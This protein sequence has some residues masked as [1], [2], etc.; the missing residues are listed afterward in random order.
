[1]AP[2]RVR[3]IE[4]SHERGSTRA[5]ATLLALLLCSLGWLAFTAS[6][7]S[8]HP[9]YL[10]STP[11]ANAVVSTAPSSITISYT[12]GLDYTYCHVSLVSPAGKTLTT[13]RVPAPGASELKV[14]P[15]PL[16]KGT[17]AVE[18]TAIGD[19]GHVVQGTFGFSVGAPS[20][21]P[22]VTAGQ[23]ASVG[24]AGSQGF[25]QVPLRVLLPVALMPFVGILLLVRF[26]PGSGR[27]EIRAKVG[28]RLAR[29]RLAAWAA[30]LAILLGLALQSVLF[31][32]LSDLVQSLTGRILLVFLG[33]Y[34]LAGVALLDNHRLARGKRASWPMAAYSAGAALLLC[35]DLGLSGHGLS[36]TLSLHRFALPV[37]I[38][39]YLAAGLWVGALIAVVV[40]LGTGTSLGRELSRLRPL[41]TFAVAA[42]LITGLVDTYWGLHHLGQVFT[43]AWGQIV[44]AKLILL[45]VMVGLGL[46]AARYESR[47]RGATSLAE[48]E[49]QPTLSPSIGAMA[50][51]LPAG[52]R[53]ARIS[54]RLVAV[55]AGIF[56]VVL[57][58]AGTLSQIGQPA[59]LPFASQTYRSFSGPPMVVGNTGHRYV[60]IT[61]LPGTVGKNEVVT[62]VQYLDTNGFPFVQPGVTAM[63]ADL[64]CPCSNVVSHVVLTRSLGSTW[65]HGSVALPVAGQW[66]IKVTPTYSR[67]SL[68]DSLPSANSVID[69]APARLPK[70]VTIGTIT[71]LSGTDGQSCYDRLGGLQVAIQEADKLATDHGDVMRLDVM[72][73][74]GSTAA[75]AADVTALQRNGARLI[76]APCGSEANL[77]AVDAQ[78]AAHHLPVVS[79][80]WVPDSRAPWVWETGLNPRA[81]GAALAQRMQQTN[82][83]SVM[84]VKGQTAYDNE[85]A[86]SA[87]SEFTKLGIPTTTEAISDSLADNLPR[88]NPNS[89]LVVANPT[90]AK[91]FLDIIGND[92]QTWKPA[93]G[94]LGCSLL[95]DNSYINSG[96]MLFRVGGI[97]LASDIDPFGGGPI[98]YSIRLRGLYPGIMPTFNGVHAFNAGFVAVTA[99]FDGGGDPT[100]QTLAKVLGSKFGAWD[101][102]KSYFLSLG[103]NGGGASYISYFAT[104]Y[105]SPAILPYN[106]A[107][108]PQSGISATTHE[109]V[110]LNQGGFVQAAPFLAITNPAG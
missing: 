78:A 74:G 47:R 30:G 38:A 44:D 33:S 32:D 8:A 52:A 103:K 70:Q 58:L 94:I 5:L 90:E 13:K 60:P 83:R 21:N 46:T 101:F 7:A 10:S 75:A 12:E 35:V 19:D 51:S 65:W 68:T 82:V 72:D 34:I 41:V 69:I 109:G 107:A 24:S 63:T 53:P 73:T 55:E 95:M 93:N 105:L 25:L 106:N 26:L 15:P 64:A 27:G 92:Y 48:G 104:T 16:G 29:I 57:L 9:Y 22:A 66:S 1:M 98:Y 71:D 11:S 81:E 43:Y 36:Q 79:T 108:V 59:E 14:I 45:C 86:A 77:E 88:I 39:H 80:Q 87:A 84:I 23:A 61:V 97:D 96:G 28:R 91:G 89:I 18:W 110:F 40:R 31:Y 17:Y 50:A 54:S 100:S 99:L 4:R 85:E 20:A 62:Q 102:D 56:A 3:S 37:Y 49:V 67:P 2:I 42:V 6:P 76:V